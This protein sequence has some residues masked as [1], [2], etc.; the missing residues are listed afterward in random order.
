MFFYAS[1]MLIDILRPMHDC[2]LFSPIESCLRS[3][4]AHFPKAVQNVLVTALVPLRNS[5]SR[6]RPNRIPQWYQNPCFYP[7]L[8]EAAQPLPASTSVVIARADS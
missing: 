8:A 4:S 6:L 1:F 7:I 3:A 5:T 2:D